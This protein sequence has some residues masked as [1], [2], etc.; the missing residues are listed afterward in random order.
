MS[1]DYYKTLGVE[2]SATPDDIKKSFRKLEMRWNHF[3]RYD[4]PIDRL[5]VVG[6][7]AWMRFHRDL[8]LA[9]FFEDRPLPAPAAAP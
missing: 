5:L 6:D 1:K 3:E 9:D 7:A 2:K 8:L 4:H